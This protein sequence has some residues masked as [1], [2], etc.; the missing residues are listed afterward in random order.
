LDNIGRLQL[1]VFYLHSEEQNMQIPFVISLLH[2]LHFP[3][4]SC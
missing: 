4:F 1:H 3:T 2:F